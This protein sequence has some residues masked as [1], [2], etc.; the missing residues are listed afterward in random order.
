MNEYDYMKALWAQFYDGPTALE[1]PLPEDGS[2]EVRRRFL[3]LMDKL[4]ERCETISLDSFIA[5]FKLAAGI[6]RE[7]TP[8]AYYL[9]AMERSPIRDIEIKHVLKAALTDK[10]NDRTVFMKGVDASYHY[11]GYHAFKTEEL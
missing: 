10:I 5:G 7:I 4:D 1:E 9:L 3:K 6:A 8:S 11:E 2:R